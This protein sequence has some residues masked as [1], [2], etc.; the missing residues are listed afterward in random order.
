[1]E[2]LAVR[3]AQV[4]SLHDVR[5]RELSTILRRA[6]MPLKSQYGEAVTRVDVPWKTVRKQGGQQEGSKHL[7]LASV[8]LEALYQ[9]TSQGELR[10]L[11]EGRWGGKNTST[12][13]FLG[14]DVRV[15]KWK[16]LKTEK[17]GMLEF[18]LVPELR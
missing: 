3:T 11:L 1:M 17:D 13:E 4:F 12:P 18:M 14:S 9:G 6:K 15:M 16:P 8:V 5:L 7:R 2:E 10:T